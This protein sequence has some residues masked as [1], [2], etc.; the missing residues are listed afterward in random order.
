M[1]LAAN[2]NLNFWEEPRTMLFILDSSS[3][4]VVYQGMAMIIDQNV[5]TL[6]ARIADGVTCVDG[7]VFLGI[8]N[9]YV[10]IAAS[11]PEDS[12]HQVELVVGP[13]IVGFP[14]T[15][16]TN[17]NLGDIVYA[18]AYTSTGVTLSGSNGAYP[19]IGTLWRVENGY[20]YV[21][22]D[23]PTNLDVP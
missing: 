9:G 18:S 5:D 2:I 3:A 21:L 11:D 23:P 7:D 4:Q 15:V 13:S 8:S 12:K 10:N 22:L 14:S 16:F 1:T 20:A 6:Y 19:R 17:A